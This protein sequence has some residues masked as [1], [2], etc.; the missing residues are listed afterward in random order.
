M[1]VRL[2]IRRKLKDRAGD[3]IFGELYADGVP[4][5]MT[6][7]RGWHDNAPGQSCV[8]PGFYVLSPHDGTKYKQTFALVGETVAHLP[9][10]GIPRSACVLHWAPR[11]ELLEGCIAIGGNVM[12]TCAEPSVLQLKDTGRALLDR[13]R[14]APGP[15]YLTIIG[16]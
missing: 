1:S 15:H 8:P 11:G 14:A 6:C 16:Q 4:A 2:L 3:S 5:G 12:A 9:T 10:P 7:E 13:L